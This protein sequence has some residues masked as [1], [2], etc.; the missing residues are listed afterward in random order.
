[1][2]LRGARVTRRLLA[3]AGAI[4]LLIPGVAHADHGKV[5]RVTLS[6][7]DGFTCEVRGLQRGKLT[8]KTDSMG[9]LSI[10]WEDVRRIASPMQF[11][12]ELSSGEFIFGT[13]ESPSDGTLV[14]HAQGGDQSVPLSDVVRLAP[15]EA[16]FWNRLDGSIDFGFSF[17]QADSLTQWTF[18]ST[19]QRRTPKYLNLITLSSQETIDET[20]NRQSRNTGTYQVQRFLGNRWFFAPT[21]Q[22]TQN[23]QLGLDLR[24]VASAGIGRYLLQSNHAIFTLAA[25]ITYTSEQFSGED[26][27]NRSEAVGGVRWDWFTFGDRETD[28]ATTL[29]VYENLGSGSRTRLEATT[30]FRRKFFKDFYW[31]ANVY[32]SFDSNPPEGQKKNDSSVA[33]TLGWSF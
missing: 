12:V 14:V 10:E 32:E 5:D 31:S 1:M 33:L 19:I 28:L 9:T 4:W 30:S 11:E 16:G 20:E 3:I 18:N 15:I 25:G 29:Q 23:E 7:G 6:N 24:S 22:L 2:G 26:V 21:F 8:A 17:A 13:L 27:S